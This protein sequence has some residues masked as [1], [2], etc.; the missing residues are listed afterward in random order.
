MLFQEEGLQINIITGC[1]EVVAKVMFLFMSVIL[2]MLGYPWEAHTPRKHTP[3]EAHP[4]EAHTHIPGKHTPTG[5]THTHPRK[6]HPP[7]K[8]TASYGP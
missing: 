4:L 2:S 3:P 5:S 1:N 6:A 7:R 8:Q